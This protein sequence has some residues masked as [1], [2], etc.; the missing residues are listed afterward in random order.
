MGPLIFWFYIISLLAFSLAIFS[1]I[2]LRMTGRSNK[3]PGLPV[4]L[5]GLFGILLAYTVNYFD[6]LFIPTIARNVEKIFLFIMIIATTILTFGIIRI[7]VFIKSEI[8]IIISGSILTLSLFSTVVVFPRPMIFNWV[9]IASITLLMALT[10]YLFIEIR[11]QKIL[12]DRKW[13]SFGYI[14]LIGI[15]LELLEFFLFHGQI[16]DEYIPK[17]LLSYSVFSLILAVI[18]I[19]WNIEALVHREKSESKKTSDNFIKTYAIT[20]R[21]RDVIEELKKGKSRNDIANSLYI[22]IR[23]VDRHLNNVYRKCGVRN[24]V[25]LINLLD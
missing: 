10:I 20:Q 9:L 24:P 4:I 11:R 21:E 14:V 15:P 3:V 18:V 8:I 2:L 16:I 6:F 12:L 25:E 13:V 23:T 5:L 1:E 7:A 17:G 22:S 19:R